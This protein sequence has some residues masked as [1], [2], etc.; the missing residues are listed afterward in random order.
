MLSTE[1]KGWFLQVSIPLSAW[2]WLDDSSVASEY[3]CNKHSG[4]LV[5]IQS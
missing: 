3:L 5:Q 4:M 1:S 2:T